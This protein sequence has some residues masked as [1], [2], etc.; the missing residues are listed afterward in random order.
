MD[1]SDLVQSV[2][3]LEPADLGLR[4][5]RR[6]AWRSVGLPRRICRRGRPF[7]TPARRSVSTAISCSTANRPATRGAPGF[8]AWTAFPGNFRAWARP[9]GRTSCRIPARPENGRHRHGRRLPA[10]KSTC[11]S[12]KRRT[13]QRGRARRPHERNALRRE[14]A[15]LSARRRHRRHPRRDVR[16][17][18]VRQRRESER[19]RACKP[20]ACA[21]SSP[22]SS[23]R[24][25]AR[26]I[27]T[28]RTTSIS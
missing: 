20:R 8:T 12:D 4:R 7:S 5:A 2:A 14:S 3:R 11:T 18:I 10:G 23:D 26:G 16:A 15:G 6:R 28:T 21:P 9:T 24:E 22:D 19:Q 13:G 1:G 27:R 17:P 25:T